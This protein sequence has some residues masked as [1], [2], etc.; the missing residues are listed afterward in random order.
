MDNVQSCLCLQAAPEGRC[1]VAPEGQ[2]GS[3]QD[4]KFEGVG[5]QAR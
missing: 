2:K 1:V 3:V 4:R 5:G